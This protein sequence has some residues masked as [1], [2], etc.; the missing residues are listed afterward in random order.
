MRAAVAVGVGGIVIACTGGTAPRPPAPVPTVRLPDAPTEAQQDRTTS[1]EDGV[2]LLWLVGDDER[3][4]THWIELREG[5]LLRH[6]SVDG[7]VVGRGGEVWHWQT[8]R[9]EVA[10]H[11]CEYSVTGT[12]LPAGEGTAMRAHFVLVGDASRV[13]VVS[14]PDPDSGAAE[15]TEIIEP[16]ASVG[17]HVFLRWEH[18]AH[19]CGAHGN[20][21]VGVV[22]WDVSRGASVQFSPGDW[23]DPRLRESA[24]D[25]LRRVALNPSDE[26]RDLTLAAVLP[27]F[28]SAGRLWLA[29]VYT[30]FACYACSDDWGSYR[31]GV[32]VLGPPSSAFATYHQAPEVVQAYL[33]RYP[34]PSLRGWSEAPTRA[35]AAEA[36]VGLFEATN[37]PELLDDPPSRSGPPARMRSESPD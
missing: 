22:Q 35:S 19:N 12:D 7:L 27:R 6:G 24:I 11:A 8:S 15:S 32:E 36:V 16:M 14:E 1:D 34:A 23:D 31:N 28:D 2:A 4:R 30:A 5:A 18:Y 21:A 20:T 3:P 33:A 10:T 29:R 17:P 37:A 25:G 9:V 13:Q 26:L